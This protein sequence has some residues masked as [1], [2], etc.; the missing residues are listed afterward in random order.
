MFSAMV[1]LTVFHYKI[2]LLSDACSRRSF[3]RPIRGDGRLSGAT[4][5]DFPGS[6]SASQLLP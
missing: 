1:I 6:D 5:H 2:D 4:Q 3:D